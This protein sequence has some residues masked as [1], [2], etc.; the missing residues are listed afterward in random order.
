MTRLLSRRTRRA[1]VLAEMQRHK[2]HPGEHPKLLEYLNRNMNDAARDLVGMG[3]IQEIP[4]VT[5]LSPGSEPE[6]NRPTGQLAQP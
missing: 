6:G 1:E 3:V 5:A 2:Y 4:P